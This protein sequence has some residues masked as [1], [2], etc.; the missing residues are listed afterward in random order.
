MVFVAFIPKV[1]MT[2]FQPLEIPESIPVAFFH[3]F[4]FIFCFASENKKKV[5]SC[6]ILFPSFLNKSQTFHVMESLVYACIENFSRWKYSF[7]VCECVSVLFCYHFIVFNFIKH[8]EYYL[9]AVH[10]TVIET[11]HRIHCITS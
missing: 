4:T 10:A 8:I 2:I 5:R 11:T 7:A 1:D 6:R 3:S 9:C